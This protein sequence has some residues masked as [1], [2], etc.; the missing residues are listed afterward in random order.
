MVGH[1]AL[2]SYLKRVTGM[3]GSFPIQQ[4]DRLFSITIFL[5]SILSNNPGSCCC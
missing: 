1:Q 2:G 5:D 3:P 4:E